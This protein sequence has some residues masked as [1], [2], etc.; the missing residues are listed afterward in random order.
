MGSGR[1][2][3]D[4]ITEEDFNFQIGSLVSDPQ[5]DSPGGSDVIE[6]EEYLLGMSY[7]PWTKEEHLR[8]GKIR[9]DED[10]F[11]RSNESKIPHV[12]T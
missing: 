7:E 11:I 12:E 9:R 6:N 10:A 8:P 1:K 5:E 2:I 3:K 4:F